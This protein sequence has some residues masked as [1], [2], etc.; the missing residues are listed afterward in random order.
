MRRQLPALLALALICSWTAV[1]LAQASDVVFLPGGGRIRGTVEVYEPGRRVVV[2][3]PDGSRRTLGPRQFER[4]QFADE[5]AATDRGGGPEATPSRP[6]TAPPA[7]A[8]EPA[9][10]PPAT[11]P[12]ATAPPATAPPATAPTAPATAPTTPPP[13]G[14]VPAVPPPTSGESLAAPAGAPVPDAQAIERMAAATGIGPDTT[15]E[16][17]VSPLRAYGDRGGAELEWA[18]YPATTPRPAGFLHFG[19][20]VAFTSQLYF[21]VSAY[22]LGRGFW[23][24]G[25]AFFG[26]EIA[27]F[28]DLRFTREVQ[29][30]AHAVIGAQ[31]ASSFDRYHP[32]S[33][34]PFNERFGTGVFH[35]GVRALVGLLPGPVLAVRFGGEVGM[36]V[37]DGLGSVNAYGGPLMEIAFR[38]LDQENLEIALQIEAQSRGWH[39][40]VDE[41]GRE[42]DAV[43]SFWA[44]RAALAIAYLF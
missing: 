44:M 29:L 11:A 34:A 16:P 4:V 24:S 36:E 12:P 3:L 1:C 31:S 14:A 8:T 40:H 10:A 22:E 23:D 19:V 27:P 38:M 9:A 32:S 15:A 2:L 21:G 26:G 41:V 28:V 30:R 20:Q 43:G 25:S 18:P 33:T 5:A 17:P 35:L 37:I 39:Y 7:A 6:D 13:P 42:G